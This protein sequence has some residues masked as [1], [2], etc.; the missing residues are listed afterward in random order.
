LA[1]VQAHSPLKEEQE[2]AISFLREQCDSPNAEADDFVTLLELLLLS[3]HLPE[4]KD[5]IR[6][7]ITKFPEKAGGFVEIGM[8]LVHES[9]DRA[10]RDEL[11][12]R[13]D[14]PGAQS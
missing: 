6:M 4:A 9:G 14:T 8:S 3:N 13:Q 11:L 7:A 10:F 12:Q 2:K 5:R 1:L